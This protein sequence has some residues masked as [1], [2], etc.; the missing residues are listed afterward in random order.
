M[1]S[2]RDRNRQAE[3]AAM[4][5]DNTPELRPYSGAGSNFVGRIGQPVQDTSGMTRRQIEEQRARGD[6]ARPIDEAA[7]QA[8][9]APLLKAIAEDNQRVLRDRQALT[10]LICSKRNLDSLWI[11]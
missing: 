5:E 8:R 9:L 7:E 1:S 10:D 4:S 11:E 3:I 6:F 2:V